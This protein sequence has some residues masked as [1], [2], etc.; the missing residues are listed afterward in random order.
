MIKKQSGQASIE[1]LLISL[2]LMTALLVFEEQFS[3]VDYLIETGRKVKEFYFFT[4]R[5]LVL[6]PGGS[7]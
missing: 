2:L 4:W 1:W 3:L 5:Y 7:S 6:I